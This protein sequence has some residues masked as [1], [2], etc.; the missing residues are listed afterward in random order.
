VWSL[1]ASGGFVVGSMLAPA[2]ARRVAPVVVVVGGLLVGAVGMALLTQVD[3]SNG[4]TFLVVAS[5]TFAVGIALVVPLTTDVMIS[6]APP[7]RA[8]AASAL[9]ETGA[10]FGGALGIAVLGSVGTAVYRSR[11]TDSLAAEVPAD[12]AEAARESLGGAVAAAEDLAT[13]PGEALVAVAR[14]AFFQAFQTAA[15]VSAALVAAT[16]VLAALFLRQARSATGT[17]HADAGADAD[18]DETGGLPR[19]PAPTGA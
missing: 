5:A 17:G 12:A 16:A 11:V 14:D 19:D 9:S 13:G 18:A 4:L 8:G 6:T 1:P 15:L 3:R 10:E 7:E 2:L